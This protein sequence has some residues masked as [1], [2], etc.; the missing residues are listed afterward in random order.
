MTEI[1]REILQHLESKINEFDQNQLSSFTTSAISRK[2]H[3][4]RSSSSKYLNDMMRKGILIKINS[5][6]VYFLP[7]KKLESTYGITF[8]LN[9]FLSIGE[10][11]LLMETNDSL[12][13]K[14]I[15]KEDSLKNAIDLLETSLSY[16]Q[17]KYPV[18]IYGESGTGK[19]FLLKHIALKGKNIEILDVNDSN[20]YS[21]DELMNLS[22]KID[23]KRVLII[24]NASDLSNHLYKQLIKLQKSSNDLYIFLIVNATAISNIDNESY[25]SLPLQIYIPS[26]NERLYEE[27][28]ELIIHFLKI[29]S[30]NLGTN[31]SISNAALDLLTTISYK[32]NLTEV[33]R[34]IT[35]VCIEQFSTQQN[36]KEIRIDAYL[37]NKYSSELNR[38]NSKQLT[39][40]SVS[41]YRRE[42]KDLEILSNYNRLINSVNSEDY[43]KIASKEINAITNQLLFDPDISSIEKDKLS[44]TINELLTYISKKYYIKLKFNLDTIISLLIIVDSNYSKTI[45]SWEQQNSKSL[46]RFEQY[47]KNQ[48]P[49]EIFLAEKLNE[50]I[51]RQT[52]LRLTKITLL[53]LALLFEENNLKAP[54]KIMGLIICHGYATASSIAN[55]INSILDQFIFDAIDMSLDVSTKELTHQ[56]EKY[57]ERTT[58]SS[59]II[60]MVD[61]G[62]LENID[63]NFE[64]IGRKQ[65]AMI[66]NVS[67]KLALIV[68]S[69]IRNDTDLSEIL[70]KAVLSSTSEYKILKQEANKDAILIASEN[71]IHIANRLRDIFIKSLPKDVDI[72]VKTISEN[73]LLIKGTDH[74]VF[75][76]HNVIFTSGTI[77]PNIT[78]LPYLPIES[79]IAGEESKQFVELLSKYISKDQRIHLIK[80]I[81]KNFSLEN[82]MNYLTI[83]NPVTLL[84]Y[85]VDAVEQLEKNL[86]VQ[87]SGTTKVGLYIHA[88]C[89]SERL[90]THNLLDDKEDIKEFEIVNFEFIKLVNNSFS[91]LCEHYKIEIPINEIYMIYEYVKNDIRDN[92]DLIYEWIV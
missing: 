43:Q 53:I 12:N 88:S 63:L 75:R 76:K 60:V 81:Q 58:T 92:K 78:G 25:K 3:L 55:S 66:N 16:K 8:T 41:N 68:G 82:V 22:N 23:S 73:D 85:V 65:I 35:R 71:G 11:T 49:N 52:G 79:I 37:F 44:I 91:K 29:Q 28:V 72:E 1:E 70:D 86:H 4:S 87:L 33:K 69:E 67:T 42:V 7:K 20:N 45:N 80:N 14:I 89:L 24:D 38:K 62:S 6:P 74:E 18:L 5:R 15:G 21:N 17:L 31:F 36:A 27:R 50:L 57:I 26:F 48:N 39:Y 32:E 9:E 30:K 40:I 19:K 47:L 64:N 34:E 90:L 54:N 77:N 84:D 59:E 10:L 56:I 51:N 2:M 13:E 61:M 46:I 83:L